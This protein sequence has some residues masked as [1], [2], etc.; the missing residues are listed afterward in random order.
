MPGTRLLL[1][2]RIV[3]VFLAC[4]V[5]ADDT[6]CDGAQLAVPRHMTGHAADDRTLDAA[7]SV[8]RGAKA[9]EIATAQTA[10]IIRLMCVP[11]VMKIE[12]NV[13]Q[14]HSVPEKRNGAFRVISRRRVAQRLFA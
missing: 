9:S 5:M 10:T 14:S 6:P 11:P 8:R 12:V 3:R 13:I 2:V 4:L 7:L 1:S